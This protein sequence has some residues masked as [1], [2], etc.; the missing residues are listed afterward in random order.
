MNQIHFLDEILGSVRSDLNI[1]KKQKP[2][3][4]LMVPP[5]GEFAYLDFTSP[6][7]E[8]DFVLI[9]EIK[10]A[11]PSKGWLNKEMD[12]VGMAQ[13]YVAGGAGVISVLTEPEFFHG[14]LD[15]LAAVKQNISLP[16]LRKDF[17]IDP[18][19]VY[20]SRFFGADALLL[21]ASILGENELKELIELT[22][23]L[24]MSALVE[25]HNEKELGKA[26]N[27]GAL[28]VGINNRNLADFTVDLKTTLELSRYVPAGVIVI[29]E[30]GISSREQSAS[31]YACG[32]KGILVGEALVTSEKPEEIIRC[33]LDLAS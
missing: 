2:L 8:S 13:R 33:L 29:S 16:V 9:A 30:S 6:F 18:Y 25:T 17:I 22:H 1:R 26:L 12:F 7:R 15:D 31:L 14:S 5:E 10:R 27:A 3:D 23:A 20:E 19:Q 11:S 32:V 28:V 4:T 21:I 24:G